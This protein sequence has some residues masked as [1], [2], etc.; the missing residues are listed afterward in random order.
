[1][2]FRSLPLGR[3]NDKFAALGLVDIDDDG[4]TECPTGWRDPFL[5]ASTGTWS[6][7]PALG[8]L[9]VYDG[10]GVMPGRTWVIA[11]DKA[12]L[13]DRWN[14]LRRADDDHKEDLFQPHLRNGK[15]GDKHVRKVVLAGLGDQPSRF[16]PVAMDHGALIPPVQY[17][18]RSFDRQWI[19]PDSR[20]INQANPGLWTA[21]SDR[22]IYL[23][24][25]HDRSPT[26][27]PPLTATAAIPDLHHYA[28]RG[29]RVFPLW[30]DPGA[31]VSNVRPGLVALLSDRYATATATDPTDV[32]AYVTAVVAHPTFTTRFGNDLSTPGLRVPL[33]TD[34]DLFERAAELGRRVLWPQAFGERFADPGAGRPSGPPRLPPDRA[35]TVPVDGAISSAVGQLP[36]A[37]AYD[38]NANRLRIGGGFIANVTPAMWAYEVSGMRVLPQWF[39]YRRANRERPLMGDKRPPSRLTEIQPDRWLPEYTTE[40]LH[41]LN[42][43]GL[44][45]DIEA[46]QADLLDR[47]CDGTLLSTIDLTEA[48]ALDLP[49]GYQT[50]PSHSTAM[51][52]GTQLDLD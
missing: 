13:A 14:A 19:I 10:S 5:P 46:D 27:G 35:P 25:P 34:R 43:L 37:M 12:T 48:G 29:G 4:W 40:L 22:Q 52:G 50:K 11:P 21:H 23:T 45:I 18:F 28:A 20:L 32:F 33:T 24:A 31:T 2:R 47:I 7:F 16:M 44:L 3:R 49:G 42:V 9:F 1:V 30:L 41:V 36:D 6:T 38:A 26:S 39:S 8:D 51:P 17:A 15:P